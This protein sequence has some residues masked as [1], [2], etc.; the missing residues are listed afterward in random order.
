MLSSLCE[1]A[2]F[3]KRLKTAQKCD[4][5]FYEWFYMVSMPRGQKRQML[6]AKGAVARC[7]I[8]YDQPFDLRKATAFGH[9]ETFPV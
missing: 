4:A 1:I 7:A 9:P 8:P 3:A 6:A 5:C 2:S